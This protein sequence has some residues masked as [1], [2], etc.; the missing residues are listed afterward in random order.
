MSARR[1]APFAAVVFIAILVFAYSNVFVAAFLSATPAH[2]TGASPIET[3]RVERRAFRDPV[4][5]LRMNGVDIPL[6]PR[7]VV[8]GKGMITFAT[9]DMIRRWIEETLPGRGWRAGE[10]M[11]NTYWYDGERGRLMVSIRFWRGTMSRQLQVSLTPR[12]RS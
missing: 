9:A 3:L 4:A 5:S 10:R 6:P 8:E 11:G 2:L 1:F 7:T 12:D